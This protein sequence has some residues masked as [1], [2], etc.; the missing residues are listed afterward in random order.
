MLDRIFPAATFTGANTLNVTLHLEIPA[1][2]F[3]TLSEILTLCQSTQQELK[4]LMID[5]QQLLDGIKAIDAETTRLA[6]SFAAQAALL[7]DRNI[8]EA[9]AKTILDGMNAD[10]DR[11]RGIG[12]DPANP[13]PTA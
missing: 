7:A 12:V 11:M 3:Q 2:A 6:D 10:L 5:A 9:Q 1:T 8:T 13:V 4:K